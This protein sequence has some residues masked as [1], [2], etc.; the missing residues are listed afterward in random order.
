VPLA[1]ARERSQETVRSRTGLLSERHVKSGLLRLGQGVQPP[2]E[3]LAQLMDG[4]EC[5]LHLGCHANRG[6]HPEA[7]PGCDRAGVLEQ[8]R[9]PDAGLAAYGERP[10][11]P[12]LH[13]GEQTFD[14][15]ALGASAHQV[16]AVPLSSEPPGD[17]GLLPMRAV[18]VSPAPVL[19][20]AYRH[21]MRAFHRRE[22]ARS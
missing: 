15:F 9:L 6:R 19:S 22:G 3:R 18:S 16:H 7:G 10:A 11:S 12:G 2:Q 4:S 21:D 14:R 5:E 13:V 17:R 20:G 8:G 1:R